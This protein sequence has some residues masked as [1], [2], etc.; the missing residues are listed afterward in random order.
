M[1]NKLEIWLLIKNKD[2]NHENNKNFIEFIN[3]L[4]LNVNEEINLNNK[5]ESDNLISEEWSN[6]IKL[7]DDFAFNKSLRINDFLSEDKDL[8]N[9][10]LLFNNNVFRLAVCKTNR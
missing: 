1:K 2:K 5:E 3:D 4:L 8:I 6:T 7:K 9:F 10:C